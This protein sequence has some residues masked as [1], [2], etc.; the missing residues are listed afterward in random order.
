M[1]FAELIDKMNFM[2]EVADQYHKPEVQF[3]VHLKFWLSMKHV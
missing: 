3:H 2:I 1:S